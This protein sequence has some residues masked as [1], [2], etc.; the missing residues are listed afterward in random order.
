MPRVAPQQVFH[1]MTRIT[2]LEKQ[3]TASLKDIDILSKEI[4]I[5]M[6]HNPSALLLSEQ[7]RFFSLIGRCHKLNIEKKV[8]KLTSIVKELLDN[9]KALFS[10]KEKAKQMCRKLIQLIEDPSLTKEQISKLSQMAKTLC[11]NYDI[12]HSLIDSETIHQTIELEICEVGGQAILLLELAHLLYQHKITEFHQTYA[13]VLPTVHNLLSIYIERRGYSLD[14]LLQPKLSKIF[15]TSLMALIESFFRCA[16][17]L[18]YGEDF[19]LY[20]SEEKIKAS[21]CFEI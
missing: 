9:Q 16:S 20:P 14:V 10:H 21:F 3:P 8:N 18:A 17:H 1:I 13:N 15:E 19:G 4:E 11:T 7:E 12:Q 5:A 6:D 2:C